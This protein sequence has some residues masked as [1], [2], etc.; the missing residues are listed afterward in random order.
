MLLPSSL[1]TAAL[2]LYSLGII[3]AGLRVVGRGRE[4]AWRT[5]EERRGCVAG[6]R[7]ETGKERESKR[8][9]VDRDKVL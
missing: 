6:D 5:R 3:A 8:E 7:R 2:A 4:E 9:R 1:R